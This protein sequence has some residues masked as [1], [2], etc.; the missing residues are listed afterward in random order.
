MSPWF[1]SFLVRLATGETAV[2]DL[3]ETNPFSNAPPRFV[4]IVLYRYRFTTSAERRKT[5]NWWHREQVWVAP[6][7]S[8]RK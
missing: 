1:Q 6:G 7:W 8:L 2:I 4:R 3:L 5:G